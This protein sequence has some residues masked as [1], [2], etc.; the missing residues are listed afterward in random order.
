[1]SYF[2]AGRICDYINEKWGYDKLLA[3]MHDFGPT[4]TTTD[5]VIEESAGHEAG[6][7]RQAVLRL[8]WTSKTEIMPMAS[9]VEEF[10]RSC[11]N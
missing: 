4:V 6:G 1:M 9:N 11:V 3:M 8:A 10:A 2:Q 5:E 7:V